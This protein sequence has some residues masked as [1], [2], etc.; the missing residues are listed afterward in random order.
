MRKVISLLVAVC[1]LV[2]ML[3][4]MAAPVVA[5]PFHEVD[6]ERMVVF[7]TM[8]ELEASDFSGIVF[9]YEPFVRWGAFG[10]TNAQAENPGVRIRTGVFNAPMISNIHAGLRFNETV[11]G[12]GQVTGAEGA[13]GMTAGANA[14]TGWNSWRG[15]NILPEALN[16]WGML[17]G[18][19]NQALMSTDRLM[20]GAL[21]SNDH[22]L[23]FPPPA[24]IPTSAPGRFSLQVMTGN[25][26]AFNAAREYYEEEFVN[27]PGPAGFRTDVGALEG[28]FVPFFS[29]F[30][31]PVGTT[32]AAMQGVINNL[33]INDFGLFDA[34]ETQGGAVWRRDGFEVPTTVAFVGFPAAPQFS[35]TNF[36]VQEIDDY[37]YIASFHVNNP[38]PQMDLTIIVSRTDDNQL[39]QVYLGAYPIPAN[40]NNWMVLN[41]PEWFDKNCENTSIMLWDMDNIM[42]LLSQQEISW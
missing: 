15:E 27:P 13:W 4:L 12:F 26:P 38:L 42:P 40:F 16:D 1:M 35:I 8:A 11:L 6:A 21:T 3:P 14:N 22:T 41:L 5:S 7:G 23:F 37:A 34:A 32:P 36:E 31:R 39:Q 18:A 28:M 33:S 20:S 9:V 24:S 29:L 2:V 19:Y 17:M 30:L 10:V 25:V